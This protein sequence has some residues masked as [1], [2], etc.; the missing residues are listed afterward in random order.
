MKPKWNDISGYEDK[1]AVSSIG[2]IKNKKTGRI[3]K[4][5]VR[6][7]YTSVELFCS[8]K[9]K[10]YLVHRLVA[11]AFLNGEGIQV[12][13]RNH[14][15]NDNRVENLEW[16]TANNNLVEMWVWGLKRLG[17]TVTPPPKI[18]SPVQR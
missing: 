6:R 12:H 18:S 10:I 8:G 14:N 11:K 17:Y 1:Y 13:H 9:G 16:S 4:T 2:E 7:G 3:L 15:R 5:W